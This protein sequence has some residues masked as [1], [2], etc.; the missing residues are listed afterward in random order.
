MPRPVA[1][2]G[3]VIIAVHAAALNH[4][5]LWVRRGLPHLDVPLPHIGGSDIAGRIA[6]LADS[7]Q[8]LNVGDRVLINPTLW[9]GQCD[10][11]RRGEESLCTSLAVL[12]EHVPGGFAEFVA[13]PS[14]NVSPIPDDLSFEDAAAV[15]LVFQTAWRGLIGR[16]ELQA[17]ETVLILGASGGVS[18]AAIQIAKLA[19]ARVFA[20]T[21]GQEKARRIQELGADRVFDRL[22]G[23][24]SSA[25]WEATEK[26]GVDL[27]FDGVGE[28]VWSGALRALGRGGRLVTYGHTTG[29]QGAVDIRHIYWKQLKIIGTT[30]ASRSEFQRVMSL[31]FRKK[32]EPVID[33]VWPLEKARQAHE[34][35]EA[36]EQLGKIVLK[37]A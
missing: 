15:P 8:D 36:G 28:A 5:D 7:T 10:W 2:A 33:V 6:E 18:T 29:H 37:I 16:G 32:L 22:E 23:D 9:C 4:L 13:V 1:G 25:V 24:F 35:L 21:A 34:R 31:V 19:G 30:M 12:G 26:R 27:V 20:V 17:S 14:L 3:Q 11:C